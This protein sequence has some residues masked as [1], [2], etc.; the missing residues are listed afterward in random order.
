MTARMNEV[1]TAAEVDL[2]RVKSELEELRTQRAELADKIRAKVA[3]EHEL[4][5]IIARL[6]PRTRKPSLTGVVE[7]PEDPTAD[8]AIGA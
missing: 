5:S 8:E 1:K 2:V 4:Y 7:P 3:E 6:T